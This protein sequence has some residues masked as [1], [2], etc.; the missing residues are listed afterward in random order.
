MFILSLCF[1]E[2][3]EYYNVVAGGGHMNIFAN[4]IITSTYFNNIRPLNPAGTRF[5]AREHAPHLLPAPLDAAGFAALGVSIHLYVG[6]RLAEQSTVPA[7][8]SA[9]LEDPNEKPK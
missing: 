2:P 5:V 1:Q 6:L 3:V 7:T 4:G 8:G 9:V